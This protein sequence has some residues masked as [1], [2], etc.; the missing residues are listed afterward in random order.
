[1]HIYA[2]ILA[3]RTINAHIVE[4][5]DRVGAVVVR[6]IDGT[7]ALRMTATT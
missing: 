4:G 5:Q 2:R 3:L 1:M 6:R 7:L